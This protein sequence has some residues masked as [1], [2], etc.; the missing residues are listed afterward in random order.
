MAI[1]KSYVIEEF[2]EVSGDTIPKSV[3]DQ[4]E[5]NNINT[6]LQERALDVNSFLGISQSFHL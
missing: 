1:F 2:Q 6:Y 5:E 3:N 4:F